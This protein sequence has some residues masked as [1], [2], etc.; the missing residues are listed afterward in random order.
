[1]IG[2]FGYLTWRS[3]Y[4]R[5]IRQI[6][7]L[8]SPRYLTAL[9]LGVAYIWFIVI[10]QRPSRPAAADPDVV[11]L[12]GALALLG[13]FGDRV[14]GG[15]AGGVVAVGGVGALVVQDANTDARA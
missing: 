1:M 6:R 3:A 13:G 10:G 12:I 4:N 9:L 11:E 8:Q 15:F 2:V 14:T 7:R 5:V